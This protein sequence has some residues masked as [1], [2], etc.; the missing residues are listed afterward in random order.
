MTEMNGFS[1]AVHLAQSFDELKTEITVA[2]PVIV[3]RWVWQLSATIIYIIMST[4]QDASV[5]L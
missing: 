1:N 2:I 4:T 5:L 3:L